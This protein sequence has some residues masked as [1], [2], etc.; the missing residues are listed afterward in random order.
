MS[1]ALIC[2]LHWI[3]AGIYAE[4]LCPHR[5]FAAIKMEG[6]GWKG[7]YE[8]GHRPPYS[9]CPQKMCMGCGY[10]CGC[11]TNTMPY[12]SISQ[13]AQSVGSTIRVI[14]LRYIFSRNSYGSNGRRFRTSRNMFHDRTYRSVQI[15]K[16]ELARMIYEHFCAIVSLCVSARRRADPLLRRTVMNNAARL[17]GFH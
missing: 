4:T 9:Q 3:K 14:S 2:L 15:D 12:H 10:S 17:P 16:T 13:I 6:H 1:Q 7:D 11:A 5:A 8:V